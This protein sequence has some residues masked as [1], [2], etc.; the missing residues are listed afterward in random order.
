M[1]EETEVIEQV[2]MIEESERHR[3]IASI[4]DEIGILNAPEV[5]TVRL[6]L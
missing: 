1:N 2:P 4:S 3:A 5:I 6:V